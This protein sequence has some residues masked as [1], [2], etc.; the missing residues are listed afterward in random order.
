MTVECRQTTVATASEEPERARAFSSS[1]NRL[2]VNKYILLNLKCVLFRHVFQ[3]SAFT[4]YSNL[5]FI[6]LYLLQGC[7]AG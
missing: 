3:I 4:N 7:G 1:Y 2:V 6:C 5:M